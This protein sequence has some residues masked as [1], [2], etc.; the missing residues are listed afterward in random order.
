MC[1]TINISHM[2]KQILDKLDAI[3]RLMLEESEDRKAQKEEETRIK[4]EKLLMEYA[5]KHNKQVPAGGIH[6]SREIQNQP[7]KSDGDLVPFNLS[8]QEKDI[9]Q[10]FYDS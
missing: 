6:S 4:N 2:M 3:L 9:L 10:M 5:Q 1:T 7:V 8:Q